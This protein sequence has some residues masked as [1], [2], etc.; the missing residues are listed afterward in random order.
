MVKATSPSCTFLLVISLLCAVTI[1]RVSAFDGNASI[2]ESTPGSI[3]LAFDFNTDNF[4]AEFGEQGFLD[5]YPFSGSGFT[6]EP[7]KPILPA[8]SRI[9]V[10]PPDGGLELI[11]TAGP[12]REVPCSAPV[13]F[14]C[15]DGFNPDD[16]NVIADRSSVYPGVIAEMSEP[17][18]IRG[19]RM[20]R[21][22]TYPVQYNRN[23]NTFTVHDQ[24][25]TDVRFSGDEARNPVRQPVRRNRSPEFLKFMRS[26]AVNGGDVGR[27]DPANDQDPPYVGHYLIVIHENC[28]EFAVPF[29]EWRRKSGWKV[30]IL[31]VPNNIATNF[32]EIKDLIQERYDVYIHD[33]SDPFDHILLVGDLSSYNNLQPNP[34]WVLNPPNHHNDWYFACLEG[35]DNYADVG[36]SRWCSGN[37]NLMRLFVNKTLAYEANPYMEDVDWFTRAGVYAQNWGRNYHVSL[38]TNVR[39]GG[40]VLEALNFDDIYI[41]ENIQTPDPSG[42][43]VGPFIRDMYNIG[44][45]VLIGRA[46]N[47]YFRT[48]LNGVRANEIFPIDMYLGG[49]QEYSVWTLLRSSTPQE[50]KGPVAV[51]CG[52]GNPQTLPMSVI[53]LEQVSG[54]LLHDMTFGWARLK[55]VIG[56]EQYIPNFGQTYNNLKIDIMYYGDPGIQYWKGVPRT[57]EAVLPLA[58]TAD[59][60]SIEVRVVDPEN[61]EPVEGVQVTLYVPGDMPEADDEDYAAYDEMRMRTKRSDGTGNAVF[62]IDDE[63]QG[64]IAL[65]TLSGRD[66]LPWFGEIEIRQ[67][68]SAISLGDYTLTEIEGD[69]D[70]LLNPGESFALR[71]TAVNQSARDDFENVAAEISSLSPWIEVENP[72]IELGDI[73]AGERVEGEDAVTLI[74]HPSCPDGSTRPATA[75]VLLVRFYNDDDSWNA[76]LKL[77]IS[78]PNIEFYRFLGGDQIPFNRRNFDVYLKNIG[79]YDAPEMTARLESVTAGINIIQPESNYPAIRQGRYRRVDGDRFILSGT[80]NAVPGSRYPLMII[81]E[82]QA[83]FVDT[84]YFSLQVGETGEEMPEGPDGY[85]YMCLDDTDR[86]WNLAPVFNWIEISARDDDCDFEGDELDFTGNSPQDIGE[87]QVLAL[88]FETQF[89]GNV[90]DEITVCTNGFISMGYQD[91]ITNFQNW[92]LDRAFGGGMGMIAPFWDNLQWTNN[93]DVYCYYDEEMASFTIEWYRMR[94]RYGGN[95][96]LTFQ[97]VL[98]DRD[99]WLTPTGDQNVLFQYRDISDLAGNAGWS[100]YSPYASVGISSPDGTTGINYSYNNQRPV[101]SAPLEDQRAILFT[102]SLV[103]WTG[104]LMGRVTDHETAGPLEGATITTRHGSNVRSNADGEWIISEAA[105]RIDFFITCSCPGYNDSILVDLHLE[106]NDTLEINFDLLHPEF[107]ASINEANAGLEV[108]DSQEF[109]LDISNRGNGL[110]E[111]SA[112]KHIADEEEIEPWI[113]RETI[114]VTQV[115]EDARINGVAFFND[116]FYTTGSNRPQGPPQIYVF[117]RNGDLV[118]SFAQPGDVGNL[119]MRDLAFNGEVLLG[120]GSESIY[121]FTGEGDIVFEIEDPYNPSQCLAWDSDHDLVWCCGT[122][123]DPIAVNMDGERAARVSRYGLR[124]YGLAYNPDDADNCNLY[125]YTYRDDIH[126]LYKINPEVGDTVFV[127]ELDAPENASPDGAFLSNQWD[128]LNLVLMTILDMSPDDQIDIYQ[129]EGFKG[130]FDLDRMNGLL[131]PGGEDNLI[132][133]LDAR[134]LVPINYAGYVEFDHNAAGGSF[135]LPVS[136]DV[137]GAR[138]ELSLMLESGWNMKSINVVPDELN[139]QELLQPLVEAGVLVLIKN[140]AGEF[141]MPEFDVDQIGEWVIADGYLIYV[142]EAARLDFS[143]IVIMPDQPIALDEGWNMKAFYPRQPVDAVTAL[144]Q[145]QDQLIIAKDGLGQFYMPEYDFSNMGFMTEGSGYLYKVRERVDLVYTVA[146]GNLDLIP[147]QIKPSHF[148]IHPASGSNMSV[149]ALGGKALSGCELGVFN[150]EGLLLGAGVFDPQGRCGVAVW[151]E[152]PAGHVLSGARKG[153]HLQFVTWDGHGEIPVGLKPLEGEPCWHEDCVLVGELV[154]V[155]RQYTFSLD[156]PSPNPT[157][158]PAVIR[159]EL[160]EESF[161][162]LSIYDLEG[163]KIETL[164]SGGL[165]AGQHL[166][167]WN[168]THIP[169]GVYLAELRIPGRSRVTKAV[170]VK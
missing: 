151:G 88:P 130:W 164:L 116:M 95:A 123:T 169:S 92:P 97:V 159:F 26:I 105:A 94:H 17:F 154:S 134:N 111:W 86:E 167:V 5:S 51:T 42:N 96:D 132:L 73:N 107:L 163:R 129:V 87:A 103:Q 147:P 121:G 158:G 100:T 125:V 110:L 152:D 71:V 93:S 44:T 6:Y 64:D 22:T 14:C 102:T 8:V 75:P 43:L 166:A 36:I 77:D 155:N 63:L 162:C 70:E 149:L 60:S 153:D 37:E 78:A 133:T 53:W 156:N 24:I 140:D 38:A 82:T 46:E 120:S 122:T 65:V 165:K 27:D 112:E 144:S 62:F 117:N 59:A 48:S 138:R 108:N 32:A 1:S 76:H 83:G 118:E 41:Y 12:A 4:Q 126:K 29:I 31:S 16:G 142:T 157:N 13:Q 84:A 23:S 106:E 49:H 69:E 80:L 54:F 127:T 19:A 25:Q 168:T 9:I 74:I 148:R 85:G 2:L 33:G 89:Y 58:V 11:V 170:V 68:V 90:Y 79:R 66:I 128:P 91:D 131:N 34:Q 98:Y 45:N 139:I 99:V 145:I 137:L 20:V 67:N 18:I 55:G 114:P 161:A 141:Y 56:P 146:E 101:T 28:L 10:V 21:I 115:V 50:P 15:E 136:L 57:V 30:E 119:G 135:V 109:R 61:D 143:G 7:G 104:I 3:T 35:N 40:L 160:P 124:I 81:L 72:L 150:D 47:Y 39:W 52:W 113:S